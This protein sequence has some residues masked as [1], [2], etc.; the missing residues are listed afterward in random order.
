MLE[1][2]REREREENKITWFGQKKKK[3][4]EGSGETGETVDKKNR[5]ER[6]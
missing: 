3:Q 2:L 4:N 6:K 5:K 1:E